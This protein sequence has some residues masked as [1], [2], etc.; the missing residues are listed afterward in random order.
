[1]VK[2]AIHSGVGVVDGG[3]AG[4]LGSGA[5]FLELCVFMFVS[6]LYSCISI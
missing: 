4:R 3:S 5:G 6:D 2:R 1:M